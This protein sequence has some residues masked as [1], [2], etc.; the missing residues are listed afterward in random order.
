MANRLAQETSPYL[1]QHAENPVDWYPWGEEALRLAREQDKPILLSVGYSACHWCHVMAHESFEDPDIAAVMNR[2]FVN[3]K[4]DR[5]ERPDLDQ[6]YQ[7]AQHLLTQRTGGWPLTMFLTPDQRPFFGGTYFPRTSRYNLPGFGE[8]LEKVAAAYREQGEAIAAQNRELTALLDRSV[9]EAPP[10]GLEPDGAPLS[11]AVDELKRMLDQVHGGL[12]RAPKFPHAAELEL[13]LVRG[14]QQDDEAARHVALFSLRKMAEGGIYDQ[15]GGGFSRYS[16][17]E[18]WTIPHFEKMLYDNGPLLRLYA[19]AWQVTDEPLFRRVCEETAAWVMREMQSPDGG[20]YSSLDADSEHV[21]GKFYVWS[22]EEVAQL[23]DEEEYAL[24]SAHYGLSR[25]PNFEGEHWHLYVAQPLDKVADALGT[26]HETA[27]T[28]LARARAKLLAARD[29]RV[30]PGRDEK[31]LTSWNALMIHGMAHAGRALGR[32]DWVASARRALDFVRATLW[33]EGRLLATYKDGKAHL[34]AYLD[35]HAFLLAAV[36]EMMQTQFRANDLQFAAALAD[37]L[38][39]QFEDTQDGGFFFTG[40]DHEALIH[41][42]KPGPDNATPSGNGVA[43]L[44]LQRFAHLVGEPRYLQSAQRT[45]R[46]F[47][48]QMRQQASAFSTLALALAEHLAPP[49]VVVVR[50]APRELAPW[51]AQLDR[52]YLPASLCL[53]LPPGVSGL[54]AVLDKPARPGVNAWVCRGVNCLP[55]I[56]DL[57]ELERML[58]GPARLRPQVFKP[59]ESL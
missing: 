49:L 39:D 54:P 38:V 20:Y 59:S 7:A 22:Q 41:R 19:D 1:Q 55:P 31:I 16:V 47:W 24:V 53:T 15:I 13:A 28:I 14:V 4:V 29:T 50:G 25:S 21:E 10:A 40:R 36:L 8:L 56:D 48:P 27:R 46:L 12:G 23:L 32:E 45:L 37:V 58:E 30:R 5:E 43:A 9:P 57:A 35:D 44:A 6:I 3:I 34:D 2:D 51:R 52:R 42:P 17:D 11:A 33:V 26:T 18:R